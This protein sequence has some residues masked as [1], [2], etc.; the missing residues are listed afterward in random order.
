MKFLDRRHRTPQVVSL[1]TMVG[2]GQALHKNAGH[3]GH[4]LKVLQAAVADLVRPPQGQAFHRPGRFASHAHIAARA[5]NRPGTQSY[6]LKLV[7]KTID[8][9]ITFIADLEPAI[10]STRPQ[11]H[12]IGQRAGGIV[13]GWSKDSRAAGEHHT[14]AGIGQLAGG[15]QHRQGSQH[16]HPGAIERLGPASGHLQASQMDDAADSLFTGGCEHPFAIGHIALRKGQ[17][18][19][20]LGR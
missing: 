13:G 9:G 14:G 20:L 12:R 8:P 4:E 16:I 5:I 6:S 15:L 1:G 11:A 19:D 2:T 7:V 17:S 3:I 10:M 18:G